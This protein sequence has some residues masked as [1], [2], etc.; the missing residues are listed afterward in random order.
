MEAIAVESFGF[1]WLVKAEVIFGDKK[2]DIDSQ[3]VELIV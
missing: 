2:F 1:A 3:E